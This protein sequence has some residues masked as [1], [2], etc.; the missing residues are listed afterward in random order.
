MRKERWTTPLAGLA[1]GFVNGLFGAGGGM[2]LLP[3]L[4]SGNER[5]EA[6]ATGLSVMLLLSA[7]SAA[8]YLFDGRFAWTELRPYLPGGL[9]G[10]LLGALTLRRLP[11]ALLRRAFGAVV[12][13]AGV[14]L[15]LR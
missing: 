3:A 13:F 4:S 2:L 9:L 6:H 11:P 14:R 8:L 10:G 15:L 12:V 1:A 5:R 7:V